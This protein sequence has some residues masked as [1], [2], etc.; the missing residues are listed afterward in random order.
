VRECLED[1]SW[2]AKSNYKE[3]LDLIEGLYRLEDAP[4]NKEP[5]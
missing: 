3:C 1:T 5:A 2:A 4:V